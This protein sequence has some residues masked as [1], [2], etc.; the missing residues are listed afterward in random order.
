MSLF[1]GAAF[2]SG[3]VENCPDCQI[4]DSP[5]SWPSSPEPFCEICYLLDETIAA[6]ATGARRITSARFGLFWTS[7]GFSLQ[8]GL[9]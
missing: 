8:L 5:A 6:T 3:H 1:P 2:V 9:F 7:A 4:D